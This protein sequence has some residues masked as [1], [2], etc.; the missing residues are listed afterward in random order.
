MVFAE[1]DGIRVV[2]PFFRNFG[3]LK[4][5]LLAVFHRVLR[6]IVYNLGACGGHGPEFTGF[7]I[8]SDLNIEDTIKNCVARLNTMALRVVQDFKTP[9][10]APPV[11]PNVEGVGVYLRH[12]GC[13]RW[14]RFAKIAM[15]DGLIGL[16]FF[17][18][19]VL[20]KH[21]LGHHPEPESVNTKTLTDVFL[22]VRC[23]F[24]K[25]HW[26]HWRIGPETFYRA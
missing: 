14:N 15:F 5:E 9:P 4:L 22:G 20:A 18:A 8:T 1:C 11:A 6:D 13:R 24:L 26:K 3:E 12:R 19:S 17:P 21:V 16:A 7:P 2:H 25:T 10:V 23:V